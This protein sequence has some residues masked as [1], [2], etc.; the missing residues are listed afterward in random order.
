MTST[1]AATASGSP[2]ARRGLLGAAVHSTSA[3][4]RGSGRRSKS[5][6]ASATPKL[7]RKRNVSP[8]RWTFWTTAH[9]LASGDLQLLIL[10]LLHELHDIDIDNYVRMVVFLS[11][12]RC[13][14]GVRDIDAP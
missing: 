14:I 10:Q 4:R 8:R 12:D 11:L 6:V 3:S 2:G 5:G 13:N 1:V 7:C 9:R